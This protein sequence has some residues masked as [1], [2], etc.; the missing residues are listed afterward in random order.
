MIKK[1]INKYLPQLFLEITNF[2]GLI[3]YLL[4]LG[5]VLLSWQFLL[6]WQLLFGL[7]VNVTVVVII[8]LLY[9]KNRPNKQEFSNFI[10]RLDASSFPSLHAARIF[11]MA[12]VFL[13]YFEN[14]YLSVFL[15]VMACLVTYSRYY[16]RKHD[17]YDLFGGLTL[18]VLVFYVS[19][20]IF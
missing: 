5:F 7:V 11:F 14:I 15:M 9:F 17:S 8:R 12:L 19:T 6:F 1:V 20:F 16:L 3:F 18:G 4:V 2:G 10:E 13:V